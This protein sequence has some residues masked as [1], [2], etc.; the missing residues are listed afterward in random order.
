MLMT[1]TPDRP[2]VPFTAAYSAFWYA[3]AEAS[4]PLPL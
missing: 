2:A 3:T 4:D 1:D